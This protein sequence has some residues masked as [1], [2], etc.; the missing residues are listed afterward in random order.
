MANAEQREYWEGAGGRHWAQDADRYDTAN[1]HW[2][3][4]L[5]EALAP[6]P[7]ERVL[8]VG[9]GNGA[10]ALEIARR[11]GPEGRVVGVDLSGPMLG[12]ARGRAEEAGIDNV[13]FE[14]ADAQT[15]A[16]EPASFDAV[17]S[18]FGVMFFDDPVAAFANLARAV[19]VGGRLVVLCWQELLRNEWITVPIGA[20]LAH[21]PMPAGDEPGAPGPFAFGD[22][23]RL[24]GVLREAGWV[25]VTLED[26]EEPMRVGDSPDD[27]L[28]FMQR[29]EMAQALMKDVPD[30]TVAKA[31]AA[32][33]ESVV[34]HV[35][36]DGVVLRGR[37]WLATATKPM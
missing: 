6:V 14:H 8:E 23:E 20:A 7:G 17:T 36:D 15:H 26:R 9:C 35:G 28:A 33:R 24:A 16:F 30:E 21:V 27:F 22:P 4:R 37:A 18:R 12:T 11:V 25:D 31:W 1:R 34:P 10:V 2:G 13:A 19:R 3:D 32:V 5:V 29:T